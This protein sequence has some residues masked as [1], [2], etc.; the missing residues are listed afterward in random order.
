MGIGAFLVKG[1]EA[2][3]LKRG[4]H[5]GSGSAEPPPPKPPGKE[6][7]AERESIRRFFSK[8]SSDNQEEAVSRKQPGGDDQMQEATDAYMCSRCHTRLEDADEFQYHRDEHLARDLQEEERGRQTFA[9]Q[10]PRAIATPV[11]NRGT[12]VSSSSSTRPTKRK[13]TEAGQTRLK[14]A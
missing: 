11:S 2:V 3:S 4:S 6:K 5:E 10:Y 1:E 14:F 8:A 7:K 9:G 13:K 12:A